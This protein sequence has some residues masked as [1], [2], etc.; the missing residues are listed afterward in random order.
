MKRAPKCIST[1][2]RIAIC[3][4]SIG[5]AIAQ[6]SEPMTPEIMLKTLVQIATQEDLAD[7]K[8][9]GNLLG[10]D[11]VMIPEPPFEMKDG[12]MGQGATAKAPMNP[13]YLLTGGT[14]FYYRHS[15]FPNRS[16]TFSLDFDK[17]QLCINYENVLAA[18]RLH[19]EVR[20]SSPPTAPH[21]YPGTPFPPSIP[22]AQ[23]IYAYSFKNSR[24]NVN[25]VLNYT[26]CLT[27]I[28][29]WQLVST[30]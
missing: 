27:S 29:I 19:G 28:S 16:A 7:E 12:R 22:K 14:N 21:W 15:I 2:M 5:C 25:L 20:A 24:S 10:L 11:I 26:E 3:F 4:A 9:I 8:R 17:K 23:Q 6:S 1:A 30:G 18:F 13:G